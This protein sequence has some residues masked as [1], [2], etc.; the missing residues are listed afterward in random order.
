[1]ISLSIK[2][3]RSVCNKLEYKNYAENKAYDIVFQLL[4]LFTPKPEPDSSESTV[5]F[6]K[7]EKKI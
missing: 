3:F 1:M 5:M 2:Q 6:F 4:I 7:S